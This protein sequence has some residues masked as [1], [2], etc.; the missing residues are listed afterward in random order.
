MDVLLVGHSFIR[1]F[2]RSHLPGNGTDINTVNDAENFSRLLDLDSNVHAVYSISD[3]INTA[4]DLEGVPSRIRLLNAI[5]DLAIVD[6]G[7]NDLAN[8]FWE[9]PAL[10]LQL[11]RQ[12]VDFGLALR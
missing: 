9:D 10:C 4:P 6:F 11:A 12:I 2:K 1:R 7:S 3:R 5:P 8:F